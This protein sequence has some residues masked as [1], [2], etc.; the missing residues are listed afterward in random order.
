MTMKHLLAPAGLVFACSLVT[1]VA[2][3]SA[4]WIPVAL[5]A[6]VNGDVR[7]SISR[8]PGGHQVHFKNFGPSPV[9]FSFYIEG[10]QTQDDVPLNGR[11]HIKNGN[12]AGPFMIQSSRVGQGSIRVHV[13]DMAVDDADASG[14]SAS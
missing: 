6:E 2:H 9:H 11:V 1:P 7:M 13:L 8:V 12:V 14:A 10:L 3:A 4:P 5:P